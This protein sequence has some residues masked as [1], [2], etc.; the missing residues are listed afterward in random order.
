MGLISRNER[1]IMA[2]ALVATVLSG[3]LHYSQVGGVVLAF[4]FG[5][6]GAGIWIGLST[7]LAVVAVLLLARWLRRDRHGLVLAPA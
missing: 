3:I 1:I 4:K 5:L 2:T 6:A 7:G